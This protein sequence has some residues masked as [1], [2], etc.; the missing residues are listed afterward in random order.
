MEAFKNA[1]RA[2]DNAKMV[3]EKKIKFEKDMRMM[4]AVMDKGHQMNEA[5]HGITKERMLK[6][7]SNKYARQ[8]F[9]FDFSCILIDNYKVF[10]IF[11][12]QHES[13][14]VN[15]HTTSFKRSEPLVSSM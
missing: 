6:I 8:I 7:E 12:L 3:S 11:F 10:N 2:L 15:G 5:K 4:L 14:R 1:I 13:T 9:I